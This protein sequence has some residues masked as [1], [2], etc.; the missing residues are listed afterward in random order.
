MSETTGTK[1]GYA[2]LHTGIYIPGSGNVGPTLNLDVTAS[3]IAEM[4]LTKVEGMD[5]LAIKAKGPN[6]ILVPGV[7]LV[8]LANITH[9]KP[10]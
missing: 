6:S 2:V 1:V 7:T 4:T 8:P 10:L 3:K 5:F 9:L